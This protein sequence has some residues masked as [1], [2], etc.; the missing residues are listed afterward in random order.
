MAVTEGRLPPARIEPGPLD[1]EAGPLASNGDHSSPRARAPSRSTMR[2]LV[3]GAN[4]GL[5]FELVRTWIAQGHDV[6]GSARSDAPDALLGLDPAGVIQLDLGD[7]ASIVDGI[8]VLSTELDGLD[9]KIL[10]DGINE[11]QCSQKLFAFQGHGCL[12]SYLVLK[13]ILLFYEYR[14][15]VGIPEQCGGQR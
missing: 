12:F 4:R 10:F 2:I 5:G 8:S 7:E 14:H 6:W 15:L 1:G 9:L 13:S 3:T 11:S